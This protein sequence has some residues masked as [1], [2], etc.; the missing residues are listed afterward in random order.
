MGAHQLIFDPDGFLH[1]HME[2]EFTLPEFLSMLAELEEQLDKAA[3]PLGLLITR[4]RFGFPPTDGQVE[5]GRIFRH[6]NLSK[7]AVLGTP[8]FGRAVSNL[9]S[10]IAKGK[11]FNYFETEAE[12]RTFLL[13]PN[14]PAPEG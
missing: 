14:A 5:A 2:G 8:L 4:R 1:L 13:D 9:I 7:L 12:A 11:Y 3:E 10:S 6:P